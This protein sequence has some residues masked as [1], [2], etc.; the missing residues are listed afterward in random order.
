MGHILLNQGLRSKSKWM[1]VCQG[2][3][4]LSRTGDA[5]LISV[6]LMN[7]KDMDE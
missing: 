4:L 3:Q 7:S 6:V 5:Q 1:V 2:Q